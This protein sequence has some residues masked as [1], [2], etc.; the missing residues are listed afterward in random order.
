MGLLSSGGLGVVDSGGVAVLDNLSGLDGS[1]SDSSTSSLRSGSEVNGGRV[2][3]LDNL[4][5]HNLGGSDRRGGRD[6]GGGGRDRDG[7]GRGR[8]G[9]ALRARAGPSGASRSRGGGQTTNLLGGVLSNDVDDGLGVASGEVRVH[10]S[11]ND[12]QVVSAVDLAVSV[13]DGGAILKT[14]VG[15]HLGGTDE[16]RAGG[17][18]LDQAR[19]SDVA[20]SGG[21][22]GVAGLLGVAEELVEEGGDGLLVSVG[23]QPRLSHQGGG[24]RSVNTKT[25]LRGETVGEVD[26]N[27]DG[28]GASGRGGTLDVAGLAVGAL[29]AGPEVQT[30]HT[31]GKRA[32]TLFVELD[33]VVRGVGGVEDGDVAVGNVELH[34][35]DGVILETL[36]D[37]QLNVVRRV[38]RD[39]AGALGNNLE[40]VSRADTRVEQETRSRQSTGS[41]DDLAV[42]LQVDELGGA[43]F[44]LNLN[45]SD[46][47]AR[48]GNTENLG[49]ELELEVGELL[50]LGQVGKDG[51]STE[52]VLDVPRGVGEDLLLLVGL[53]DSI[54]LAPA[55]ALEE[56]GQDLVDALV[57]AAAILGGQSGTG[58]DLV[59]RLSR[60]LNVR[61]LPALGPVLEVGLLGLD[62][63]LGVDDGRATENAAS[64]GSSVGAVR[65]ITSRLNSV[66]IGWNVVGGDGAVPVDE[67]LATAESGGSLATLKEENGL[68][69]LSET[70]GSDDTGGTTT[71]NDV[72]VGGVQGN[73]GGKRGADGGGGST[74]GGGRVGTS[75]GTSAAAGARAAGSKLGPGLEVGGLSVSDGHTEGTETGSVV[76]QSGTGVRGG[77]RGS[78]GESPTQDGG[79]TG[80]IESTGVTRNATLA[81]EGVRE[82]GGVDESTLGDGSEGSALHDGGVGVGIGLADGGNNVLS[83]GPAS[84]EG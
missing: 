37:G 3:I 30:L 38:E 74:R 45:T 28:T 76:A 78:F 26:L 63:H 60:R 9:R 1:G 83:V 29:N 67:V 6:S 24:A 2:A 84:N 33:L 81:L 71:N 31:L 55:V 59:E 61:P 57:V 47:R 64:L 22:N 41:K 5:G 70:L 80:D 66:A 32:G 50:G 20:T 27:L 44:G 34:G 35:Q 49:V 52:R 73:R 17:E 4:G 7:G 72:V 75:G 19:G 8:H 68:L 56:V 11:V 58:V 23:V 25:T 18:A 62:E 15:T 79:G 42:G 21:G 13:D 82:V 51:T 69:G 39:T 16:V 53:L 36:A 54:D 12:E 43:R 10:R 48:A 14:G 40:L 46:G 65:D 77:G